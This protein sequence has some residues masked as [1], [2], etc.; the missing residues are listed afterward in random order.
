MNETFTWRAE[1]IFHGSAKDFNKM[2]KTLEDL[3]VEI[4]IPEWVDRVAHLAGCMPMT[5]TKLIPE[6]MLRELIEGMPELQLIYLRD[7]PGGIRTAHI[8]VEDKVVLLDTERFSVFA[9]EVAQRLATLRASQIDDYIK[10]MDPINRLAPM[11]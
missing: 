10:V 6:E 8:H 7:I 11:A 9:G 1:I 5:V 4:E 3:P 2:T